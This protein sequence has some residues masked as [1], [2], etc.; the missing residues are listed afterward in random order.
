MYIKSALN[1]RCKE[2]CDQAQAVHDAYTTMSTQDKKHL[3]MDSGGMVERK[4]AWLP[5]ITKASRSKRL[6]R[7]RSGRAT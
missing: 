1:G 6:A 4:M 7:T 2:T 5:V 3:W